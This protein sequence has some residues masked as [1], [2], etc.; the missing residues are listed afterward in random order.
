MKFTA[1]IRLAIPISGPASS[2]ALSDAFSK[3]ENRV[4]MSSIGGENMLSLEGRRQRERG[5][6]MANHGEGVGGQVLVKSM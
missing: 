5:W 6:G 4:A 2:G 3:S 1:I